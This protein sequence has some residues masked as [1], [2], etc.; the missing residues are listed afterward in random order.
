[1]GGGSDRRPIR[2]LNVG[3]CVLGAAGTFAGMLLESHLLF[4]VGIAVG[5]LGYLGVRR[6]LRRDL[7]D[8]SRR[9]PPP[10]Q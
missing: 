10:S 3:L 1:M 6:E 4:L 5:I 9:N 7:D 2:Q 8:E